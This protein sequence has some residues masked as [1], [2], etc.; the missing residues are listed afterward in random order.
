MSCVRTRERVCGRSCRFPSVEVLKGGEGVRGEPIDRTE[1]EGQHRCAL[2]TYFPGLSRKPPFSGFWQHPRM[3]R[4]RPSR[5]NNVSGAAGRLGLGA[6]VADLSC[7]GWVEGASPI[8]PRQASIK[9][10]QPPTQ[11]L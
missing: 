5:L 3:Y 2:D 7:G 6:V 1:T 9:G 8:G 11:W 4:I 10:K